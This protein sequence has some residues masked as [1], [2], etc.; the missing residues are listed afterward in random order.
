MSPLDASRRFS[1]VTDQKFHL[2]QPTDRTII[3]QLMNDKRD[4]VHPIPTNAESFIVHR[5]G[6]ENQ[7]RQTW[8]KLNND[9]EIAAVLYSARFDKPIWQPID[10]C[11]NVHR[12]LNEPCRNAEKESPRSFIFYSISSFEKGAGKALIESVHNYLTSRYPGA[13]LST[14]SPL[15][16]DLPKLK[17]GQTVDPADYR[18]AEWVVKKGYDGDVLSMDERAL[19][20]AVLTYLLENRHAVQRFH[21]GNGAYIGAIRLNANAHE[22]PDCRYAFNVMVNYIYPN[23]AQDLERNAQDYEQRYLRVYAS[24][25]G[26]VARRD[27]PSNIRRI[28]VATA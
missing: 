18:F 12:I 25:L 13:W 6:T 20:G 28:P 10:L 4:R 14:L 15:R 21:M 16:Q 26:D 1:S 27:D 22:S 8:V 2:L 11:G 23:S 5:I 24:L 17:H 3:N 7:T 9:G 19:R